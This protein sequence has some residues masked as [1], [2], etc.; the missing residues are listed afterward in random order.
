[1]PNFLTEY[2]RTEKLA[3]LESDL[4]A[5]TDGRRSFHNEMFTSASPAS[6]DHPITQ[7]EAIAYREQADAH[8][9]HALAAA[10][11]ALVA[12]GEYLSEDGDEDDG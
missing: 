4:I 8:H 5:W 9:M 10:I 11:Q 3:K 2:E 1:M 12:V 6:P 7:A